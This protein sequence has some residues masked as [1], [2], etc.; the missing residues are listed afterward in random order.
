MLNQASDLALGL[1]KDLFI[2]QPWR[3]LGD[4][5]AEA[6]VFPQP[7]CVHRAEQWVFRGAVITGLELWPLSSVQQRHQLAIA[8][9]LNFELS[10][11]ASSQ[12]LSRLIGE[13]IHR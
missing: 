6:V 4:L 11:L 5:I 3:L 8:R 2:A 1:F 12:S 9:L 10:A 13:A 7:D